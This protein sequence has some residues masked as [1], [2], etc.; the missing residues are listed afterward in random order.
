MNQTESPEMTKLKEEAKRISETENVIEYQLKTLSNFH[1]GD[2]AEL[3]LHYLSG[4]T[5]VMNSDQLHIKESGESGKG[6]SHSAQTVLSVFPDE[7]YFS[8]ASISPKALYYINKKTSLDHKILFFDEAETSEGAIPLLRML[9]SSS[10][11]R[12]KLQHWTVNDKKEG[13]QLKI[14]GKQV[15]WLNSSTPIPD[16]QLLNR[17]IICNPDESEEQDKKVFELQRERYC[18]GIESSQHEELALNQE[19]TRQALDDAFNVII[20]YGNLIDFPV[21]ENRRNPAKFFTLIKAC[22]QANLNQREDIIISNS[23]YLI[24]TRED[25]ETALALWEKM[26]SLTESRVSNAAFNLYNSLIPEDKESALSNEELAER[27]GLNSA[28]IRRYTGEL[29]TNGLINNSTKDGK[30]SSFYYKSNYADRWKEM[31]NTVDWQSFE[32]IVQNKPEELTV[33]RNQEL[34]KLLQS[35]VT[36]LTKESPFAKSLHNHIKQTQM[37]KKPKT[38]SKEACTYSN[39][40]FTQYHI[41]EIEKE[42]VG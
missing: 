12:D 15:I 8:L 29:Y 36:N 33:Q 6:K 38:E 14:E 37:N 42:Y 1:T 21:K 10:S 39:S 3:T 4:L 16:E 35:K 20:P 28:T 24:A 7:Y 18:S 19:V 2:I 30:R 11:Q 31:C 13:E 34:Y 9:T 26:Q 5:C 23:F 32:N 41:P 27:A 22:A 25:Y 40:Q 17:F